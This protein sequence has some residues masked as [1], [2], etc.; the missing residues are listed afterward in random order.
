MK[1]EGF[2]G[3]AS[4]GSLSVTVFRGSESSGVTGASKG[5]AP[6]KLAG[7]GGFVPEK[8]RDD[9]KPGQP[10]NKIYPKQRRRL[11]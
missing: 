5:C 11:V 9:N 4:H 1:R 7:R 10:R 2:V 3:I 8:G 6:S